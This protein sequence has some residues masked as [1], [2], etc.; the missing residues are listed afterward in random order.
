MISPG[1]TEAAEDKFGPY[2]LQVC[3]PWSG[4][5]SEGH[6]FI[7]SVILKNILPPSPFLRRMT[8]FSFSSNIRPALG[9]KLQ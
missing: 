5:L 3:G 4:Q 8:I 1:S 2:Q 7:Y 6:F 9:F